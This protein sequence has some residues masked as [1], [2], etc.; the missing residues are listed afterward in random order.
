LGPVGVLNTF[1]QGFFFFLGNLW[2]DFIPCHVCV[3][4]SIDVYLQY[5]SMCPIFH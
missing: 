4:R 2:P 5:T 1:N 3:I